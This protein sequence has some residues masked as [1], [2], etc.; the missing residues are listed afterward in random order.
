MEIKNI[1][2]TPE[3]ELIILDN[4]ISLAMESDNNPMTEPIDWG[5]NNNQDIN[6]DS[7]KNFG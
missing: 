2:I 1:Y 7:F 4:D 3:I 6:P 5:N